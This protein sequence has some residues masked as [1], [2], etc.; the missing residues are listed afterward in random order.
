MCVGGGGGGG[1]WWGH[2]VAIG[3]RGNEKKSCGRGIYNANMH[4][5]R[6]VAKNM[7]VLSWLIKTLAM[8]LV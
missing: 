6:G 1:A 8:P 2:G 5:A 7:G 3:N 4:I